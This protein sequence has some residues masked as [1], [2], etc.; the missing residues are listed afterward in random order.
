MTIVS[1]QLVVTRLT[2]TT[3]AEIRGIDLRQTLSEEQV[4][5]VH[6]HL[7]EYKVIFFPGQHLSSSEHL[8]LARQLGEPTEAHPIDR[9]HDGH[10]ELHEIDYTAMRERLTERKQETRPRRPY[11]DGWHTDVT[12]MA[13]PPSASILNALV[14]PLHGGDTVFANTEAA[15]EGLSAP[16]QRLVEELVAVHDG[17][18]PFGEGLRKLGQAQWEG[19]TFT[20]FTPVEHPVVRTHPVSGR[21]TL[22]VNPN[23]TSYVKDVSRK[24]SDAILSLLY[25]HMIEQ[26][27]LVRYRWQAGDLA[28]WDNRATMHNVVIDY[29]NE[30][31]LI[32]RI[33]LKGERPFGPATQAA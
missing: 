23:F 1:D 16:F 10:P 7:V 5:E 33:T 19:E 26:K 8:A 3:G 20:E 4:A 30:H 2:G 9:G 24:E 21:R 13:T 15:Y 12:F 27:Y 6:R 11:G 29:G 14:M 31:R 18:E 22:F 28:I 25:Q 17:E 32:Q